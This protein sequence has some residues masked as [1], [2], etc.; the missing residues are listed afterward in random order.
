MRRLSER[1]QSTSYKIPS[2]MPRCD[3][4]ILLS[5]TGGKLEDVD[6]SESTA[7]YDCEDGGFV[8]KASG[9]SSLVRHRSERHQGTSYKIPSIRPRCDSEILLS[10]TGEKLE[11]VDCHSST[12]QLPSLTSAVEKTQQNNIIVHYNTDKE[13]LQIP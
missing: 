4:E 7:Q 2:I 13:V 11:D 1:R 10:P 6:L 5:T 9:R 3:S 8:R 12:P